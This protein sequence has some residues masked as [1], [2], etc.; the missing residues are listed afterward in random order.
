MNWLNE[1]CWFWEMKCDVDFAAWVQAGGVLLAL[2]ISIWL[3][4]RQYRQA[5][6]LEASRR[7]QSDFQRLQVIIAVLAQAKGLATAIG[8]LLVQHHD[9]KADF[10]AMKIDTLIRQTERL[11]LFEVPDPYLVVY[12]SGLP[13]HLTH[14]KNEWQKL[15]ATPEASTDE[16]VQSINAIKRF[17]DEGIE[18]CQK[19]GERISK[20]EKRFGS[21][22]LQFFIP[23]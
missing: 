10:D 5:H 11:P 7:N 22:R 9:A 1:V 8:N 14:L 16:M 12:V 20:L 13:I 2:F 21:E 6:K 18:R 4:R 23:E 3:A 15:A 17:A 19:L